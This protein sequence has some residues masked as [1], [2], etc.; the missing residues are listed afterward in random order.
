MN[1]PQAWLEC[2][3]GVCPAASDPK[4]NKGK[5]TYTVGKEQKP[6]EKCD[7]PCACRLF[8]A[9]KDD[10]AGKETWSLER[11]SGNV[12]K[13]DE[14]KFKWICTK[15]NIE[16]SGEVVCTE[17]KCST[18]ADD[19]ETQITCK[20]VKDS[21]CKAPCR[22]QLFQLEVG[23]VG[24]LYRKGKWEQIKHPHKIHVDY[25]YLCLC[26]KPKKDGE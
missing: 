25:I 24:K 16:L 8:S 22:C 20:S 6:A 2:D 4:K 18:A 10:E 9:P 5:D 12:Y 26:L 11:D 3:S 19:D 1:L 21:E 23:S 17:G 14:K 7:A 15:P 13:A